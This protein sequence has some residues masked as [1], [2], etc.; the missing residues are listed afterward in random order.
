MTTSHRRSAITGRKEHYM[1]QIPLSTKLSPELFFRLDKYAKA[2]GDSKA[3]VVEAAVKEYL[4]KKEG[5]K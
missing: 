3:S 1:A 2:T 4:D 5:S